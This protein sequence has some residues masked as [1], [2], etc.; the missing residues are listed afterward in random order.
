MLWGCC[1]TGCAIPS[2]EFGIG[3]ATDSGA[4]LFEEIES[5]ESWIEDCRPSSG[6][7]E[8]LN[9]DDPLPGVDPPPDDDAPLEDDDWSDERSEENS[10]LTDE[11]ARLLELPSPPWLV[12]DES[13][14]W[15]EPAPLF[16]A[17]PWL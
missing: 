1:A 5:P 10:S 6:A 9:D 4:K 14:L 13:L 12:V 11:P 7:D 8:S 2:V 3:L 17:V 15:F 16:G